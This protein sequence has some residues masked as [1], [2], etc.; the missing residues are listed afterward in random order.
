MISKIRTIMPIFL[1][2]FS[3][4]SCLHQWQA[5]SIQCSLQCS[6]VISSTL[7]CDFRPLTV[8]SNDFRVISDV[9]WSYHRKKHCGR[10]RIHYRHPC[11]MEFTLMSLYSTEITSYCSWFLE[12]KLTLVKPILYRHPWWILCILT[13][14]GTKQRIPCSLQIYT[15]TYGDIILCIIYK[16]ILG[17][18]FW[19]SV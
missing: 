4:T 9:L 19:I 13:S 15:I 12:Y 18:L 7:S 10:N 2:L 6:I 17:L 8:I 5:A 3:E 14:T 11:R 1:L 16:H